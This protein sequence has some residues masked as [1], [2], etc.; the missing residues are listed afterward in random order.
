MAWIVPLPVSQRHP[1]PRWQ[2]RY[3]DQ[4]GTERSGGIYLSEKEA[5]RW[6]TNIEKGKYP[7]A[8][9][10]RRKPRSTGTAP[11]TRQEVQTFGDFISYRWWEPY[12]ELHPNSAPAMAY[13][14][15]GRILPAFGHLPLPRDNDELIGEWSD[16]IATWK[17]SLTR[18]GLRPRTVNSYLTILA[19][20]VNAAVDVRLFARSPLI[21]PSGRGRIPA[22]RNLEVG[23][24]DV[25]LT[26]EQL[27]R[28][29]D[30]IDDRYKALI[31]LA[32][33]TGLRFG[34]CAALLWSDLALDTPHDDGAVAGPGRARV[35]WAISDPAR[36]GKGTRSAPRPAPAA[37]PSPWTPRPSPRSSTTASTTATTNT[38]ASSPP[39]AAPAAPAESC[40]PPTS[41]ASGNAP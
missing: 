40:R 23:A 1:K 29:A 2:V 13:V 39:P 33:R 14:I 3:R 10:R 4:Q 27:N 16:E 36:S 21:R 28:L 24:V 30:A 19:V 12:K 11:A 20:A 7:S 26:I 18:Q 31:I 32:G 6:K 5:G 35:H 37:A 38:A 9:P 34:E 41:T 17:A 8:P 22:L 25:W 15:N